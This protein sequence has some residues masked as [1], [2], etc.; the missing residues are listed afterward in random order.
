MG[1]QS[2]NQFTIPQAEAT[3]KIAKSM[4]KKVTQDNLDINLA[5][6]AWHNTPTEGGHHS[7]VQKLQSRRTRTQLPTASELLN[8]TY[9]RGNST[10]KTEG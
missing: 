1:I 3:V 4:L 8:H 2:C 7:P 5:I 6:L 9:Q 10:Q